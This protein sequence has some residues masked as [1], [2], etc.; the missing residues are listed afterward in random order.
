MDS[1]IKDE[2][3]EI[4]IEFDHCRVF[5]RDPELLLG[6]KKENDEEEEQDLLGVIKVEDTDKKYTGYN[7]DLH[8]KDEKVDIKIEFDDHCEFGR[9]PELLGWKQEDEEEQK[10]LLEVI[11]VE[12]KHQVKTE[13]NC[14]SFSQIETTISDS[15]SE[16]RGKSE[17]RPTETRGGEKPHT[18]DQLWEEFLS[19]S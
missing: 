9:S 6:W 1:D 17:K 8:I 7:M 16:T 18:C 3:I 10:D 19:K 12:E 15:E 4:K 11:K 5:E 2:K 14:L 13:D